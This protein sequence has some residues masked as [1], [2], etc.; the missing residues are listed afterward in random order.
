MAADEII[1]VST[2]SDCG[3]TYKLDELNWRITTDYG[4]EHLKS[5][6]PEC[7]TYYLRNERYTREQFEALND[8]VFKINEYLTLKLEGGTTQIYINGQ[9]FSQC[10]YLLLNIRRDKVR[11]YDDIDS[12]DEIKNK[13]DHYL[14]ME[15]IPE[16]DSKTEF[17]GHCSNLQVWYEHD[18]DTRLLDSRLAF[19]LLRKLTTAGDPLAKRVFKDEIAKRVSSGYEPVIEYLY[20][21]GYF[22]HF[23]NEEIDTLFENIDDVKTKIELKIRLS[24]YQFRFKVRRIKEENKDLVNNCRFYP[25]NEFKKRFRKLD[26][27]SFENS[28]YDLEITQEF[29]DKYRY[30][31]FASDLE[32]ICKELFD[33]I[34][35]CRLRICEP[36]ENNFQF[37]VDFDALLLIEIPMVSLE[38]KRFHEDLAK[39]RKLKQRAERI[40]EKYN[41]TDK[42]KS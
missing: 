16:I 1:T 34:S 11:E 41:L 22:N 37:F 20:N 8:R 9:Y 31:M 24:E 5:S 4:V 19:P 26:L 2:C 10:K 33:D 7:G 21:E 40:W 25:I 6:C 17:I 39:R 14:E 12:I 27:Y 30:F 23:N 29:H 36:K 28:V 42:I 3:K 15:K 38:V 32:F 13:Y 18:Y 35:N